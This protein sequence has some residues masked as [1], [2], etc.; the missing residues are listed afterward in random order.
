M[1]KLRPTAIV[2]VDGLNLYRQKLE[3]HPDLKWLNILRLSQLM[4]QSHEILQVR[5]FTARV[6]ESVTDKNG[7]VRQSIYWRALRTLGEQISFHEGHMRADARHYRVI[8]LK[9][10]HFGQ[11][12]TAKVQKIEEKGSDVSLA[13]N[14]V[15]DAAQK[16]AD[17]YVLMSSDSDF[18]PALNL[19]SREL[20]SATAIF[21]PIEVPSRNLMATNP[22]ITKIVRRTFLEN[23]QFPPILNDKNGEFHRP[24][25]W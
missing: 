9:L 13:S 1:Q 20:G 17:L 19:V 6:K 25:S 14:L 3:Y 10:D 11:P 2:Y 5:Y 23:A 15:F 8:P 4:L 16:K 18:A 7:P 22:L 21:S 24:E 12:I